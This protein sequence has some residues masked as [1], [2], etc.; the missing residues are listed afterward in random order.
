MGFININENNIDKEH[1]CCA[2]GNDKKNKKRAEQKKAWLKDR[3]KDGLVFRRLDDRGK[4]F[5]EYMPIEHVWKPI[6]GKNYI[7]INCI[8][9]SGKFQ[10]QG[11][12]KQLLNYCIDDAKKQGK[13][14]IVV[15]T[16]SKKKGF[17]TG[18]KFFNKHNFE[19]YD[20][21]SPYFEL[22][23]LPFNDKA[24]KPHFSANAKK[25]V[26]DN[27]EGFTFMYSNQC[28][29]T[30]EYVDVMS[31]VLKDKGIPFKIIKIENKEDAQ[32]LT[33]PFGTYS[34]FYNGEI[35]NHEIMSEKKFEKFVNNLK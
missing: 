26:C 11:Y 19:T 20:T 28:P 7:V 33:S 31:G 1:I 25:G 30:E 6:N 22:M 17:L 18:K 29:F 24:D 34:I 14:G 21:A 16:A 2:I 23:G 27:K 9:V 32:K 3:L 8:W 4:I 15:V 5:I 10:K 12:A 35:V 13:D